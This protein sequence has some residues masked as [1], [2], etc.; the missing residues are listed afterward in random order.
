[1][2]TTGRLRRRTTETRRYG[3]RHGLVDQFGTL[4]RALRKPLS[5]EVHFPTTVVVSSLRNWRSIRAGSVF[6]VSTC[7]AV[8]LRVSPFTMSFDPTRKGERTNTGLAQ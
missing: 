6:S 5:V 4:I 8:F 7:C 2:A 1:M 3:R